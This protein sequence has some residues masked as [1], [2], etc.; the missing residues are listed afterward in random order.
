VLELSVD[1]RAYWIYT[2]T[3]LDNDRLQQA[4]QGRTLD[5]ALAQLV[6]S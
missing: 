3:A 4:L 1:P 2:N 6:N 5:Q